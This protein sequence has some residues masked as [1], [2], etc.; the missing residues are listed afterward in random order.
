MKPIKSALPCLLIILSLT[1][2]CVPATRADSSTSPKK[3]EEIVFPPPPDLPRIKYLKSIK[4]EGDLSGR[5]KNFFTRLWKALIGSNTADTPLLHVPMVLLRSKKKFLSVTQRRALSSCLI[6][7]N[8]KSTALGP[9]PWNGSSVLL[10]S[11]SILK[12]A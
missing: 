2:H 9:A 1:N 5:K 8:K 11:S 12:I 3:L 7:N 10:A 4:T 6:L